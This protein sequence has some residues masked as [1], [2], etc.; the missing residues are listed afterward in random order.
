MITI[1]CIFCGIK[2]EKHLKSFYFEIYIVN[3]IKT[4]INDCNLHSER[5]SLEDLEYLV[6]KNLQV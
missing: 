1:K 2:K 6:L 5:A 3:K 4:V